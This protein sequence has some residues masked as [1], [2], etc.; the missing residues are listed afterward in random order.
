MVVD[1]KGVVYEGDRALTTLYATANAPIFTHDDAFFGREVVGGPMLSA[2]VLSK[3][4]GAVA[5]RILGG[6]KPGSIKIEPMGFAAPKYDWR[7]LRRWGIS[8]SR[9]PPGSEIYF[10]EPTAWEKYRWQILAAL[11]LILFQGAMI[12]GL[13]FEH[14]RRLHFQVEAA[15]RSAELAHFNRYS[16][17]GELTASMAHELNQPLG[18]I[19]TNAETAELLL[20][21]SSPD[22]DE[23][24]EIVIDIRRD[25][26]RASDVLQRLRSLLKKGPYESK[27]VDL[28]EIAG[29]SIELLS[30]L[31]IAREVNLSGFTAPMSLPI[32]ADPIQIQ[33]VIVNLIVNAM[34]AMS[35]VPKAQRR[36]TVDTARADNF[37][38]V[39]VS[40][41]GPGIP[42][43]KIKEVFEPFFTTKAQGMGMGLSIARTIVEAHNGQIWAENKAGRGAV[44]RVSLPLSVT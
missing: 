41:T 39:S 29:E 11:A 28:N 15:R 14:R 8:E 10:R 26:Q 19:L 9:L 17:A 30:P 6:E 24:R 7:E 36:V 2:R 23:L 21:S 31:S 12:S 44:F 22:L 5:V 20:K 37:A 38:E 33:Q 43:E 13:L 35:K 3:E 16:T 1:A 18:A 40:D 34:D 42:S 25:D 27:D 4:A 32:R